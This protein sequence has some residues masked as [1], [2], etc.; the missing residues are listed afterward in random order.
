MQLNVGGDV[1]M[2]GAI[3]GRVSGVDGHRRGAVVELQLDGDEAD[4]IPRH[5]HRAILPTTLFGQ[6]YVELRS[7]RR[8]GEGH[9]RDGTVL[10]TAP[11]ATTSS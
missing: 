7:P 9:V 2:N 5:G 8:P 6:K 10:R 11:D 1:R 4:R 3:V